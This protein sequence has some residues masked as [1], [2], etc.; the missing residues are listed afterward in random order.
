MKNI[1]PFKK[2]V[3]FKTNLSEITSISLEHTLNVNKD[4]IDGEFIV[5]GEYKVTDTSTTTEPFNIEIP[6]NITIDEKYN[7][8]RAIVDIDDFYYEIVNENILSISIDVLIDKLEEKLIIEEDPIESFVEV[9]KETE[10]LNREEDDIDMRDDIFDV[11]ETNEEEKMDISEKMDS[12][13]DNFSDT[14]TF[15]AYSVCIIREG[16]NLES[17]MEKYGVSEELLKKYNS[18]NDLK[19]GD[20][21][22]IPSVNETD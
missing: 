12:L 21:L 11:L 10:I 17:I 9:K 4:N 8:S 15:V 7:T 1:I 14:D 2:D 19:I 3:M 6:F 16:D 13:F 20:K 22:I 5:S 18:L